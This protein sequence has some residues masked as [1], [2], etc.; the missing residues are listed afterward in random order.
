M[1]Q[2]KKTTPKKK[3][4]STAVK[5]QPTKTAS[6]VVAEVAAKVVTEEEPAPVVAPI[7][8]ASSRPKY[9]KDDEIWVVSQCPG[10]MVYVSRRTGYKIIWGEIGVGQYVSF[11]EL[12]AMANGQP[13]F[14]QRNWVSMDFDVLVALRMDKYYVNSVQAEEYEQIFDMPISEMEAK[15]SN[16]PEGQRDTVEIW[17]HQLVDQGKIDSIKRIEAI[18]RA[19]G[20]SLKD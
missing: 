12:T 15:L 14:F 1:E 4:T 20:I 11:E 9:N 16:I 17:A 7:V 19:L 8:S 5:K 6:P 13:K 2:I 10:V 18:E 3:T